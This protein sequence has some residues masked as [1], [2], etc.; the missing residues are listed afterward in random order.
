[1]TVRPNERAVSSAVE[2][3]VGFLL[4]TRAADGWWTDF[5][6]APGVSDEW[7]TAYVG[8]MLAPLPD[9][10]VLRA[11]ALGWNLLWSRA[12]RPDGSWG[13]NR[14]TPG[15]AD[16]T[17]WAL[18]LAAAL[19]AS[20][21]APARA[22]AAFVNSSLCADGGV[23]TY[24]RE[25]P[26]RSFIGARPEQSLSGWCGSH[27]C[28]TAAV[29]GLSEFRQACAGYLRATRQIDGSWLAYW[30]R[31]REYATALAAE[32]LAVGRCDADLVAD[33]AAW[34]VER[35]SSR[36]YAPTADQPQGSP[37]A[38][39]WCLRLATLGEGTPAARDAVTAAC[40]WLL[41]QQQAN[42]SWKPSARLL[43]PRTDDYHPETAREWK[44]GGLTEGSLVFDVNSV[45]TTA[46]VIRNLD[47]ACGY[48]AHR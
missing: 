6:L 11:A 45:F 24:G 42:G 10:E 36:G 3:G 26:I 20:N 29:A 33:A 21:T 1:M 34:G 8:C 35:I 37:F 47:K 40:N 31:D 7:V 4:A 44:Y 16:S 43:V 15:D 28:V 23:A 17:G 5:C 9:V 22:G 2:A 25:E 30:W 46:T 12:Q 13:F 14:R 19:G 41:A 38:T 48:V 39:A 32:A 18:T 27:V